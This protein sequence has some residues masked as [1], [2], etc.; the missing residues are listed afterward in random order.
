MTVLERL[1]SFGRR[2]VVRTKTAEWSLC[3]VE[4]CMDNQ[5]S[6]AWKKDEK[7]TTEKVPLRD[8]VSIQYLN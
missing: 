7:Y 5:L 8:V 3:W 1:D 6:I 2:A 4:G